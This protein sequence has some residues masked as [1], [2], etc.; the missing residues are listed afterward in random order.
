[1]GTGCEGAGVTECGEDCV[2]VWCCDDSGVCCCD[3][4]LLLWDC[5]WLTFD[6][7]LGRTLGSPPHSTTIFRSICT[8]SFKASLS[9]W[10]ICRSMLLEVSLR[11][12]SLTYSSVFCMMMERDGRFSSRSCGMQSAISWKRLLSESLRAR[13]MALWLA[14]FSAELINLRELL[15]P[16]EAIFQKKVKHQYQK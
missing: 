15:H 12:D 16:T 8:S 3:C 7:T 2:E 10:S 6:V 13:S 5:D 4:S 11:C 1:M 14:R 9:C